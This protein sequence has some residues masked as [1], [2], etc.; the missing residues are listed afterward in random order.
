MQSLKQKEQLGNYIEYSEIIKDPE[1]NVKIRKVTQILQ[2]E[3]LTPT[4]AI[5]AVALAHKAAERGCPCGGA[6]LHR[7]NA[8][9][10][11]M[12]MFIDAYD[13]AVASKGNA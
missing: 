4:H 6:D 9:D 13:A 5:F 11:V 7:I 1:L 10:A 8:I 3:G 2:Q 12:G